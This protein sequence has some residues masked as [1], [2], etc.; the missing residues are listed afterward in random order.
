MNVLLV[1]QIT[2]YILALVLALCISVPVIIHQQDFKGHCLLFS[3]GTWR[4]TDGQFVISWAPS[5]YC[6]F[7][8]ISG[9]I[10]LT[11]CCIQI[12]RLGHFLYRGL[13]SSF[14]SAFVDAVGSAFLC[15]LSL[16]SAM[17]I[18][19]GFGTWCSDI[20][21]RFEECSYAEDEN[22]DQVDN[23][24]TAGFYLLLGTAQFGA[25]ASWACWV[26]LAVCAVLKLCRYHQRENI[27]VSMAKERRRLLT[28]GL[29]PRSS[30]D[31]AILS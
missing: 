21:Q 22:I 3:R 6:V 26:G 12:H 30:S 17:I 31:E 20:T 19:L 1:I 14:L 24:N 18:T 11:A 15:F 9:V 4:E 5:S 28:D 27:R 23:I 16:A 13:D 29:P 8:I 7:V 25:W 10:L 2:V